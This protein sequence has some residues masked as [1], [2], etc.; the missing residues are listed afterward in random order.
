MVA[1]E[2]ALP[3]VSYD[4]WMQKYRKRVHE[5][6]SKQEHDRAFN[7]LDFFEGF[8]THGLTH[9]SLLTDKAKKASPTLAGLEPIGPEEIRKYLSY[10]EEQGVF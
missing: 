3:T 7:L 2:L 8:D 4:E 10:W 9:T 1:Q 6:A 5:M